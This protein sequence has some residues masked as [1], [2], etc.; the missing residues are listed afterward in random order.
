M[1]VNGCDSYGMNYTYPGTHAVVGCGSS[2]GSSQFGFSVLR[3]YDTTIIVNISRQY[4]LSHRKV[5]PECHM[6]PIT[7]LR[8]LNRWFFFIAEAHFSRNVGWTSITIRD[9][10]KLKTETETRNS[11]KKLFTHTTSCGIQWYR[12]SALEI[13]AWLIFYWTMYVHLIVHV[14]IPNSPY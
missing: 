3:F 2:W 13:R 8:D 14:I 11:L 1:K 6:G 12:Q 9:I 4:T 7:V 10:N 5:W